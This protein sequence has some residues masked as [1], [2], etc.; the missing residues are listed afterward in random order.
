MTVIKDACN[1]TFTQIVPRRSIAPWWTTKLDELRQEYYKARKQLQKSKIPS[2]KIARRALFL[3]AR[4]K[5]TKA[6]CQ[7]KYESWRKFIDKQSEENLW[8]TI[9]IF[10]NKHQPQQRLMTTSANHGTRT[11]E[12]AADHLLNHFFHRDVVGDDTVAQKKIRRESGRHPGNSR[13]REVEE[14]EIQEIIGKLKKKIAPGLDLVENEVLAAA[15]DQLAPSMATLFN[16]CLAHGV[17]PTQWKEARLVTVLKGQEK[18]KGSAAS[19]RPI[20]LLSPVGKVFEKIIKDRIEEHIRISPYQ[21]GFR[22]GLSTTNAIEQVIRLAQTSGMKKVIIIMV[23]VASAI[24]SLWW[25]Q[26]L[27]RLGRGVSGGRSCR[28]H[29]LL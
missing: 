18:D 29:E 27:V 11:W 28:G 17:F 1:E 23:D 25:P 2:N 26:I 6:V 19:Y 13:S 20:C 3:Q 24:N 15:V 16:A 4:S 5:Y 14:G 22:K 21:Y 7:A 8:K 12:D 10:K 9:E